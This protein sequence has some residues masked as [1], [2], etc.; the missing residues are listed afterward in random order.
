MRSPDPIP[1]GF[2]SVTPFLTVVDAARAI[3]WYQK[4]L[5]AVAGRTLRDRRGVIVHGEVRI[6][7]SVVILRD[8]DP[9]SGAQSP[10]ALGGSPVSLHLYTEN[11]E[12]LFERACAAGAEVDTPLD[13]S[14]FHGDLSGSIQ[15]PFGYTWTIA[16]RVEDIS[17]EALRARSDQVASR[18]NV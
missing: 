1:N 3:D 10:Q 8:E 16:Q 18:T 15:D 4:A 2:H 17:D 14:E 11:A 9:L 12:E 6:G 13:E 5:G 7:D